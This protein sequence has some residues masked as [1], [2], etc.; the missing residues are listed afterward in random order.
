MFQGDD[1]AADTLLTW[2]DEQIA[3]LTANAKLSYNEKSKMH[4]KFEQL[5]DKWM[6]RVRLENGEERIGTGQLVMGEV[7]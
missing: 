4:L 7:K 1:R 5:P 3:Q 6:V 2:L